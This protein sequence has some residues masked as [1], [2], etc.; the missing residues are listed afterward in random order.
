MYQIIGRM[1]STKCRLLCIPD[2]LAIYVAL[3]YK[4]S[5]YPNYIPNVFNR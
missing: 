5:M 2:R 1:C 3:M 4:L